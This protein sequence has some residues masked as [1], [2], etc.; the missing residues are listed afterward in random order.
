LSPGGGERTGC[1][2]GPGASRASQERAPID[3]ASAILVRHVCLL[4][5]D[6]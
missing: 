3:R 6:R 4:L 2:H 5:D 1:Q